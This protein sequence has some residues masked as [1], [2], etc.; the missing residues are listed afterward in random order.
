MKN[1]LC[2]KKVDINNKMIIKYK[3]K[4]NSIFSQRALKKNFNFLNDNQTKNEN[5]SI[6]ERIKTQRRN[7]SQEFKSN[8]IKSNRNYKIKK[9]R[10]H[11]IKIKSNISILKSKNNI[12]NEIISGNNSQYIKNSLSKEKKGIIDDKIILNEKKIKKNSTI[13]NE[14]NNNNQNI[15]NKKIKDNMFHIL[16]K[17]K[18]VNYY[19]SKNY[20]LCKSK[21]KVNFLKN[22]NYLYSTDNSSFITKNNILI[23]KTKIKKE[24]S[25]N[26]NKCLLY[27]KLL[28]NINRMNELDFS[29]N[30]SLNK[31]SD[32][33]IKK[34]FDE[35]KELIQNKKQNSSSKNNKDYKE[36]IPIK[37][38]NQYYLKNKKDCIEL[39]KK[40]NSLK[41]NI[42]G[43]I[44][45]EGN[46]TSNIST[47]NKDIFYYKISYIS[48]KQY[49]NSDNLNI[50]NKKQYS[51]G[52]KKEINTN[53]NINDDNKE[54]NKITILIRSNWGNL[55]KINFISINFFDKFSE[56]IEIKNSNYNINEPYLNRYNK[57]ETKTLIFY[58][59]KKIKIKNIEIL[60]GFDDSGIKSIVIEG[61]NGKII[62]RGNIPKKTL[63]S[64]KPF[65]ILLNNIPQIKRKG[66][67]KKN[68]NISLDIE[69]TIFYDK[70]LNG[71]YIS[72]IFDTKNNIKMIKQKKNIK[73]KE[74]NKTII[75]KF[76]E[77]YDRDNYE[78]NYLLFNE[79]TNINKNTENINSFINFINNE[80]I[81]RHNKMSSLSLKRNENNK[82]KKIKIDYQICDKIKIQLISNYGNSKYIGLSG[83]E[84]Y[85][86]NN[87]LIDIN[88]NVNNIKINQ[89]II[90]NKQKKL[91]NNLFN[92]KNDTK[93][94][95]YMFLTKNN[96]AFIEIEFKQKLKIKKIIFYNYNDEVYKDCSTKKISL[97]FYKNNKPEKYIKLIYLNKNIGEEG[98]EYG[99]IL[100]FPFNNCFNIKRYKNLNND[101]K[102]NLSNSIMVYNKEYDY[103]CPSYPSGFIIKFSLFKNWGN[104]EYIGI[105]QIKL[106]DEKNNEIIMF[107]ENENEDNNKKEVLN[108]PNIYLL[109][110]KQNINPKIKPIILTKYKN[111]NNYK[112]IN[113]GNKIYIIFNDLIILSKIRIINYYKY[114]EIAVKDIKIF[115]DDNILFEGQLN[116]KTNEIFF[117][118][119]EM[120]NY[121]KNNEINLIKNEIEPER[122]FEKEFENGTKTL[123]LIK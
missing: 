54:L 122:F 93:D 47:E 87:F 1:N 32:N 83:I 74:I 9:K 6:I 68:R 86:E 14:E 17:Y 45:K 70:K 107:L 75:K 30:E 59:D 77:T 98:I 21:T 95:K 100:K 96:Q 109:P 103:Y 31:K 29:K 44:N 102:Y 99:Q 20:G 123:T 51:L 69:R 119:K 11:S 3:K 10:E 22:N 85:N 118:N 28:R 25:I 60:N 101:I 37:H 111:I 105:E 40:K 117:S 52:D 112:N 78:N 4:N 12:R 55:S 80:K 23:N 50:F 94:S 53:E 108:L 110:E 64:N 67:I 97:T 8:I 43:N 2:Y 7:E 42:N 24:N 65:I 106:F 34:N 18:T 115:I 39:S 66:K 48:R 38:F 71:T 84:F 114:D 88:S 63:I 35:L 116:K 27:Y 73:N 33:Y 56:K 62:W 120:N 79:N 13:N 57:G 26:K 92:G 41:E 113:G 61:S 36:N 19:I 121:L 76:N 58:Y 5:I 89:P 46:N 15:K 16:D 49:N 72:N 104:D 82:N 90:N 81:I 91:I